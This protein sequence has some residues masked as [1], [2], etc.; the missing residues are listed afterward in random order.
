MSSIKVVAA[1]MSRLY[2][3]TL[4][5]DGLRPAMTM[6]FSPHTENRKLILLQINRRSGAEEDGTSVLPVSS[7][8][9]GIRRS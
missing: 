6:R 7:V 1:V 3:V 8:G 5:A 4:Q 9:K 2:A